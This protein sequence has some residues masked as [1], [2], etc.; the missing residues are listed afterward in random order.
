MPSQAVVEAIGLDHPY[1]LFL[2]S[3]CL[4]NRTAL[5]APYRRVWSAHADITAGI[6][7]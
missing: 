2:P 7:T 6:P 5:P 4:L 1:V 3:L